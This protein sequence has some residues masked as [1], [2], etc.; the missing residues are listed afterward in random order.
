LHFT[1]N[2]AGIAK[3][4]L[5]KIF[6]RQTLHKTDRYGNQGTGF[7]LGTVKSIVETVGGKISV[8]ST[9]AIGT[10]FTIS[11]PIHKSSLS[12]VG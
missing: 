5:K 12:T 4:N 7:G 6:N 11:I 3:T 2:G 10:H 8:S 1:D 9:P